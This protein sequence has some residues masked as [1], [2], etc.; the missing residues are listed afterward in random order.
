MAL[1]F[2]HRPQL[3]WIIASVPNKR[4]TS[5]RLLN[6]ILFNIIGKNAE[7]IED[8]LIKFIDDTGQNS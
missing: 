7:D 3:T 2:K 8:S 6:S 4:E 1:K 5:G